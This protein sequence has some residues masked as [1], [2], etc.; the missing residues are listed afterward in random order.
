MP[1]GRPFAYWTREEARIVGTSLHDLR[2]RFASQAVMLVIPLPVVSRLVGCK[3]PS[4]TKRYAH[5][6]DRETKGERQNALAWRLHR[7]WALRRQALSMRACR[8][9][10]LPLSCGDQHRT[11]ES[12]GSHDV[13]TIPCGF[14]I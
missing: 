4:M 13:E 8:L 2:R 5:V 1:H 9:S 3:S 7:R 12:T 6:G 11:I 10:L 14:D